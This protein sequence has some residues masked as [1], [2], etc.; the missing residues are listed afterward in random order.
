MAAQQS[1]AKWMLERKGM[2]ICMAGSTHRIVG[3]DVFLLLGPL[4]LSEGSPM[5]SLMVAQR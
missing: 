2:D 4:R 3:K 1:V 5:F